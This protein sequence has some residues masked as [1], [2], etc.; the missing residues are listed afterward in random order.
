MV[1]YGINIV[2]ERGLKSGLQSW[3][4]FRRLSPSTL[5]FFGIE[6][7]WFPTITLPSINC[8]PLS[9]HELPFV[10]WGL[11]MDVTGSIMQLVRPINTT[12]TTATTPSFRVT[13]VVPLN[14]PYC[15]FDN[16]L[17]NIILRF[18]GAQVFGYRPFPI[19]V[20]RF[21]YFILLLLFALLVYRLVRR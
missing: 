6:G 3:Q 11:T 18:S 4:L 21:T 7:P 9:T 5:R 17:L 10:L 2:V 20:I 14:Y 1:W 16:R 8:Y 19:R 13:T 12:T 15:Q